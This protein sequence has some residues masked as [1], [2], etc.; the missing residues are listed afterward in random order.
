MDHRCRRFPVNLN[1]FLSRCSCG[2]NS[3]LTWQKLE[4]GKDDYIRHFFFKMKKSLKSLKLKEREAGFSRSICF[5]IM[6]AE[7]Y[8]RRYISVFLIF[9]RINRNE[10]NSIANTVGLNYKTFTDGLENYMLGNHA[11]G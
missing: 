2:R 6:V 9:P 7:K 11:H 1:E 3:T 8:G 5:G 10:E 4:Y